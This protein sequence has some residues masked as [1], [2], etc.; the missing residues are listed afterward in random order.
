[1][2][3]FTASSTEPETWDIRIEHLLSRWTTETK[4]VVLGGCQSQ[5]RSSNSVNTENVLITVRQRQ[6]RMWV[7][8][9][10][11]TLTVDI[12]NSSQA[13]RETAKS[14]FHNHWG[15]WNVCSVESCKGR[16]EFRCDG[17]VWGEFQREWWVFHCNVPNITAK[18]M[19]LK[20][21]LYLYLFISIANIARFLS[22][23]NKNACFFAY[24]VRW[25]AHKAV[26]VECEMNR[27]DYAERFL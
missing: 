23:C 19:P 27:N 4:V 10:V 21:F 14:L 12:G 15:G 26:A 3:A 1:M 13:G 17:G 24:L 8:V 16:E 9:N 11:M 25:E 6:A 5:T 7:G 2:I 20:L 18:S 22:N